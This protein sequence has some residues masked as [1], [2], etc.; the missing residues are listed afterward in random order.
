MN[1]ALF[2]C[3]L[4]VASIEAVHHRQISELQKELKAQKS[5][6]DYAA[7]TA[8]KQFEKDV[9][10]EIQAKENALI[11]RAEAERAAIRNDLKGLPADNF[12]QLPK[13]WGDN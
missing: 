6:G 10:A 9:F 4:V 12:R 3:L 1:Y 13:K 7:A 11:Q 5:D 2:L 8:V